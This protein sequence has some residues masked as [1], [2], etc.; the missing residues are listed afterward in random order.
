VK[1]EQRKKEGKRRGASRMREF[2]YR[3]V[4]CWLDAAEL[5][6]VRKA[7]EDAGM[8]LAFYVR[9]AAFDLAAAG[10]RPSRV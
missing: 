7:A 10:G 4:E 5:A 2:G 8:A 1:K 3:R 6:L 9:R